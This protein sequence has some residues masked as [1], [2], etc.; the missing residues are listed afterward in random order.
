VQY[1]NISAVIIEAIKELANKKDA[2]DREI[3]TLKK[4]NLELQKRLDALEAKIK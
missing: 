2:Q 1:P 3:E 4:Q